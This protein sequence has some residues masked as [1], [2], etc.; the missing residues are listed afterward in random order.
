[1]QCVIIFSGK[2]LFKLPFQSVRQFV[3]ALKQ[4]CICLVFV[5]VLYLLICQKINITQL[6]HVALHDN[7]TFLLCNRIFISLLKYGHVCMHVG[8][9]A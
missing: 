2:R 8:V 5:F 1:M 6:L 4:G 9:H 7:F 3:V